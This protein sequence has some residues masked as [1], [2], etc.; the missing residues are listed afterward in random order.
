MPTSSPLSAGAGMVDSES[1]EVDGA[2]G[3]KLLCSLDGPAAAILGLCTDL[4]WL[5]NGWVMLMTIAGP[6]Q[7]YLT[8]RVESVS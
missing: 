8:F 6:E 1:P 3:G 2:G 7:L 4:M 5:Y